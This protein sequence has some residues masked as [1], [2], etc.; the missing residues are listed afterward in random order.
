MLH[1]IEMWVP[2]FRSSGEYLLQTQHRL[3]EADQWRP[4]PLLQLLRQPVCIWNDSQLWEKSW[5]FAQQIL[6]FDKGSTWFFTS[7]PRFFIFTFLACWLADKT[8]N[9]RGERDLELESWDSWDLRVPKK[10]LGKG[11]RWRDRE[12]GECLQVSYY[13]NLKTVCQ[14]FATSDLHDLTISPL[15]TLTN[16]H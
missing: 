1:L 6:N 11:G 4:R 16:V 8:T 2:S 13:P 5:I 3:D 7:S 10:L 12:W 14:P 9:T 15:Y